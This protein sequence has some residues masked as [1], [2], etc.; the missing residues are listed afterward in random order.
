M[1]AVE[2]L[3]GTNVYLI[4]DFLSGPECSDWIARSERIGYADAPITVGAGRFEMRKDIRNNARVMIDDPEA[5]RALWA[6]ATPYLPREERMWLACG[7]NER[8]RLYRYDPGQ[9]F[10]PHYD[11]AFERN[12]FE[13]SRRTFMVYLNEVERG[14]ETVFY[15]DGSL[16]AD[17][18]VRPEPGCALVFAHRLLHEGA[19]VARGRKYVLRTDVMYRLPDLLESASS[20][21][22]FVERPRGRRSSQV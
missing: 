12:P 3:D 11:G 17:L 13:A 19:P 20:K 6:R 14:G 9:R 5:A 2:L 21:R 10:A 4:H 1:P 15:D 7:L 18:R 8:L 16:R 22:G